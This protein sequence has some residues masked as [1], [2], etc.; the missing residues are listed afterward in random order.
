MDRQV[1]AALWFKN[2]RETNNDAFLPLFW[3]EHRYLVLKGGGG[4]GKSIFA[5]RKILERVTTESG[6]RWLVCRKVGKTIRE[7]C[8]EQLKDQ[9]YE[10]YADQIAYIPKGKS[11]DMSM[12]FR[13]G[14][15]IL[16]TGL[17]DVEK[18]KSIYN[19]TGI[20][21]EEASEVTE[22][23]FNQLDIRLRT[24]FAYYQL[25]QELGNVEAP[26][27]ED[28]AATERAAY[29]KRKLLQEAGISAQ[30]KGV[31]YYTL[32]ASDKER[33]LM[34]NLAEGEAD[35]G[36][37]ARVLME[38]KD[39]GAELKGAEASA[40][41]KGI[42][43]GSS[44]SEEE[45]NEVFRYVLGKE[46]KGAALS[47]SLEG[48]GLDPRSAAVVANAV[49]A[50]TPQE[51]RKTVSD[52]Q[53]WRAVVDAVKDTNAQKAALL[54]VMEDSARMRYEIASSYGIKPEAWVQVKEALPQFDADNNGSFSNS[55][56]KSAIDALSG[57][58]ALL[59]PW[60]K[61]PI[62][63]SREE[64]AVLWQLFTGGK[65]GSGNPYSV[66]V[67]KKVAEE[68]ERSREKK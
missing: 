48:A 68:L 14:S 25:L 16:F 55:E 20:W 40:A 18:L 29:Q 38:L 34:D 45:K 43:A 66:R 46:S 56:V 54:T 62:R 61:E 32:L 44:L 10:H 4:S 65:S 28:V 33:E 27:G 26:T 19:V 22:W 12:R 42:I 52:A 50:L 35:M 6:H 64:K 15:E 24:K 51:G 3:D 23:D 21:I 49:N 30:G 13:N 41:K 39:T 8:F 9:A 36:E 5:G 60:N 31:V 57:N 11:G 2:L 37:A 67:G 53:K 59:A 17:D 63:L 7:S 58:G 47:D 1:E